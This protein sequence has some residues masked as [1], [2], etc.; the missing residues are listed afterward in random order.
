MSYQRRYKVNPLT[1]EAK[2]TEENIKSHK[3]MLY[4]RQRVFQNYTTTS[5]YVDSDVF[6]A[7]LYTKILIQIVNMHATITASYTGYGS[8]DGVHWHALTAEASV[9]ANNDAVI[10]DTN[11][12]AYIKLAL[13]NNSGA[14]T[15][16]DVFISGRS[17]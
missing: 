13:K 14:A 6:D 12:Y 15:P 5:S 17:P 2:N 4:K 16:V 7:R 8:V 11:G 9:S 10:A 1:I 3:G